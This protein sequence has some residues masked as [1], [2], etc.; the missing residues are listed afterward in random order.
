M[1]ANPSDPFDLLGVPA[2]FDLDK[3]TLESRQRELSKVLHPD[4]FATAPSAERRGALNKAMAVNEAVRLLKNPVARG[5]ALLQRLLAQ[6]RDGHSGGEHGEGVPQR[7]GAVHLPEVRVPGALLMEIL[8]WREELASAF[9]RRD[10]LVLD[11]IADIASTRRAA[12]TKDLTTR[13]ETLAQVRE[14]DPQNAEVTAIAQGLAALK[15][16]ERLSEEVRRLEDEF[17]DAAS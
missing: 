17:G 1:N 7:S 6:G 8:E 14:L 9:A 3:V 16:L 5:Q 12:T 13:F 11:K 15:Y 4:R 2:R 10:K